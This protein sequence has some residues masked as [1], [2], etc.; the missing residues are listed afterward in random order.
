MTAGSQQQTEDGTLKFGGSSLFRLQPYGIH[1]LL[2]V[3]CIAGSAL[4]HLFPLI[5]PLISA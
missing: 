5:C 1:P 2:S 4:R 3:I